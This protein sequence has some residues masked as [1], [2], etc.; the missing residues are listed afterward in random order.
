MRYIMMTEEEYNQ[1]RGKDMDVHFWTVDRLTDLQ[2]AV[3]RALGELGRGFVHGTPAPV[4]NA[5]EILTKALEA[6]ENDESEEEQSE[7]SGQSDTKTTETTAGVS[8]DSRR[9]DAGNVVPA[10]SGCTSPGRCRFCFEDEFL[11]D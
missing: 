10:E 8:D 9:Q 1:E 11:D 3:H 7:A 5:K 2:I 6:S 4:E